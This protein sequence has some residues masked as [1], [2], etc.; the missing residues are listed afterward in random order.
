[1]RRRKLRKA[2][3]VPLPKGNVRRCPAQVESRISS[4]SRSAISVCSGC[5]AVSEDQPFALTDP[6]DFLSATRCE[7]LALLRSKSCTGPPANLPHL[8]VET[9]LAAGVDLVLFCGGA[10]PRVRC[11]SEKRSSGSTALSAVN[12][13]ARIRKNSG[14]TAATTAG[15]DMRSPP[16][17]FDC[18]GSLALV[19]VKETSYLTSVAM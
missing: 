3:G 10:V 15:K 4:D 7:T 2:G 9:F 5:H 6:P 19:T 1:L 14:P 17:Y 16:R 11:M 8:T 12:S 13:S 18:A